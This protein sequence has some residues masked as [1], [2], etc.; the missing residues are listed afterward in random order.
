MHVVFTCVERAEGG[1]PKLPGW[2]WQT[3]SGVESGGQ[4]RKRIKLVRSA[5]EAWMRPE[6]KARG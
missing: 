3:A 6:T 1:R 5:L 4:D 2:R